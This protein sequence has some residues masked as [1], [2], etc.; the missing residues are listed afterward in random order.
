MRHLTER[1]D[2]TVSGNAGAIAHDVIDATAGNPLLS[3]VLDYI[4]HL[5][6]GAQVM[7]QA[8]VAWLRLKRAITNP[9]AFDMVVFGVGPR[10]IDF[11]RGESVQRVG[12]DGSDRACEAAEI[13]EVAAMA[14]RHYCARLSC[15][16]SAL[17]AALEL[18]HIL[19]GVSAH[20]YR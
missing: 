10:S 12:A 7:R 1:E 20:L 11:G 14:R 18:A 2:G 19:R 8:D 5:E 6:S 4:D 16:K 17:L 15:M 3:G 13:D 9:S